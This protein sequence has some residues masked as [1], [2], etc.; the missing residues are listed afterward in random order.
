[1]AKDNSIIF[2]KWLKAWVFKLK[3]EFVLVC[4]RGADLI[5]EDDIDHYQ[6]EAEL[7]SPSFTGQKQIYKFTSNPSKNP[8]LLHTRFISA[9]SKSDFLTCS[10][11]LNNP[12]ISKLNL[13]PF[14]FR[15][16]LE[17]GNESIINLFTSSTHYKRFLLPLYIQSQP[18]DQTL[19]L[20]NSGKYHL[21]KADNHCLKLAASLHLDL[22]VNALLLYPDVQSKKSWGASHIRILYEYGYITQV[23]EMVIIG[24][25]NIK[26]W[27]FRRAVHDGHLRLV[28]KFLKDDVDVDLKVLKSAVKFPDIL[29]VLLGDERVGEISV[30]DL[31]PAFPRVCWNDKVLKVVEEFV[32]RM[33]VTRVINF[34]SL[35]KIGGALGRLDILERVMNR[36]DEVPEKILS[37]TL[38]AACFNGREKVLKFLLTKV[39]PKPH[40]AVASAKMGHADLLVALLA[41]ERLSCFDV[42]GINTAHFD[43][44]I[45]KILYAFENKKWAK[46]FNQV[47]EKVL[48][49]V[50]D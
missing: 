8:L 9:S 47:L 30:M 3:G 13:T 35:F 5:D 4:S 27:I 15:S 31:V 12:L 33:G 23:E 39:D 36:I 34:Y 16:A 32:E 45:Q 43:E 6:I 29:D 48:P 40:N 19:N 50:K 42:S 10:T 41:D 37:Q 25:K 49:L 20:L 28:E 2:R 11:I 17:S 18:Q 44:K 21:S 38:D 46:S 22:I 7:D 14:L 1:L 24:D 26:K